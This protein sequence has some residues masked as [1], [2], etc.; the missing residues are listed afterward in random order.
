MKEEGWSTNHASCDA[1]NA[2]VDFVDG[3]DAAGVEEF[4]WDFLLTDY[5]GR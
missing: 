2:T 5:N 3:C 4:V 1:A